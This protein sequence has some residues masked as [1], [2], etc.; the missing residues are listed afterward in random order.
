MLIGYMRVSSESDRQ[1]THLQK[2]AL[3]AV[4]IDERHL[5]EDHLSGVRDDR[6]GLKK[7]LE[8]LK[9]GDV[10]VVWKLDRLGHSLSHLLEIINILKERK[11]GF[12]SLTEHMDTTAPHG[13]LLFHL[14]GALSQYERSLARERIVAGLESARKRGRRGGRPR[15]IDEEKGAV[16][17]QMLTQ[18][19]SKASICR[20]FNLPRSTLYDM[21]N[22][23]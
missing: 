11:V 16:I 19:A 20:A 9:Q 10:L 3:M 2:D 23:E 1:T 18:G 13:E 21:I 17:R 8:F 14:F 15:I 4:G 12:R 5:F 22:R 6:P 7:A